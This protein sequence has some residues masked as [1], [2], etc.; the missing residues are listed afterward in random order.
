MFCYQYHQ[1]EDAPSWG[2]RGVLGTFILADAALNIVHLDTTCLVQSYFLETSQFFGTKFAKSVQ[3]DPPEGNGPK[4][5]SK[6][7]FHYAVGGCCLID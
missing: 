2:I 4:G 1:G 5:S 6:A 3:D 7:F